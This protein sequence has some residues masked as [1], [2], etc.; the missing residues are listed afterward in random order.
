M[1]KCE[2]A[3][4]RGARTDA[5]EYRDA[6]VEVLQLFVCEVPPNSAGPNEVTAVLR[7][8]VSQLLDK[9]KHLHKFAADYQDDPSEHNLRAL[10]EEVISETESVIGT[11]MPF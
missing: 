7:S 1:L 8:A 4:I 2:N 9:M 10:V 3:A 6:I 5:A 11:P